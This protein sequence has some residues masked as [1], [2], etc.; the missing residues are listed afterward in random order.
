MVRGEC[1]LLFCFLLYCLLPKKPSRNHPNQFHLLLGRVTGLFLRVVCRN[2][3][4][5]TWIKTASCL[6]T[7]QEMT[8]DLWSSN[9]LS[10][11]MGPLCFVTLKHSVW[12][13]STRSVAGQSCWMMTIFVPPPP[14]QKSGTHG[15]CSG[16]HPLSYATVVYLFYLYSVSWPRFQSPRFHMPCTK[17]HISLITDTFKEKRLILKKQKEKEV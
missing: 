13:G 17:P 6:N 9:C 7:P 16:H 8:S 2:F 11:L 5:S 15:C 3:S 14:S 10:S 4:S 1:I 12:A